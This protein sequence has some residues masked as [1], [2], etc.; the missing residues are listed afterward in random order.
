MKPALLILAAIFLFGTS[1]YA[2]TYLFTPDEVSLKEGK[3]DNTK[4]FVPLPNGGEKNR[5][6]THLECSTEGLYGFEI[7]NASSNAGL[8][9]LSNR[10]TC[11]IT[12]TVETLHVEDD[13]GTMAKEQ[14]SLS[15]KPGKQGSVTFPIKRNNKDKKTFI[16]VTVKCGPNT[17]ATQ[18][19]CDF[20][21]HLS[22]GTRAE[23]G[24][25]TPSDANNIKFLQPESVTPPG[26]TSGSKCATPNDSFVET[27]RF[28]NS[29]QTDVELTF[30]TVNEC[31]CEKFIAQVVRSNFKLDKDQPL[32]GKNLPPTGSEDVS[33]PAKNTSTGVK[34]T[35]DKMVKVK[36]NEAIVILVGCSGANNNAPCKGRITDIK[37]TI[38]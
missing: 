5:K 27:Y 6:R 14:V 24:T 32:G 19:R 1:I 28:Y 2:K 12:A 26:T 25:T 22:V 11:D 36:K 38:K 21:P 18:S 8:F 9:E 10:G 3:R 4:G 15:V 29:L 31:F 34:G 16:L 23:A 30:T 17:E 33:V 37:L 20:I 35:G 7:K 13:S